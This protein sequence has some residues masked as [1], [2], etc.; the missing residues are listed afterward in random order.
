MFGQE[1]KQR[2]D[3]SVSSTV[4]VPVTRLDELAERRG[5]KQLFTKDNWGG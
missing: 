5:L 4:N 1:Y 3:L 2:F